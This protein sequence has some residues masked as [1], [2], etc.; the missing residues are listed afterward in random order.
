MLWRSMLGR[1]GDAAGAAGFDCQ[2][3]MSCCIMNV[4]PAQS[5][6]KWTRELYG[7]TAQN[8]PVTELPWKVFTMSGLT[9]GLASPCL[10]L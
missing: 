10:T 5:K 1:G 8:S 9:M 6:S 7:R 3:H 4:R 2:S